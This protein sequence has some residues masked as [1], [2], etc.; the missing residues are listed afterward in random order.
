MAFQKFQLGIMFVMMI[1]M[2]CQQV[3]ETFI[4]ITF[5]YIAIFASL[6]GEEKITQEDFS[7]MSSKV[8]VYSSKIV[9]ISSICVHTVYKGSS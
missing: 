7:V 1:F 3:R 2:Y 6:Q 9:H 8:S 4:L 5:V